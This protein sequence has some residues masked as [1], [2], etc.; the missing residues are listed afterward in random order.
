MVTV[1]REGG[2]RIVIYKDDHVP[3]H[4]HVIGDGEVIVNLSGADG[5]PEVRQHHG[6]T[7]ADIR[8]ALRIVTGRLVVL[9]AK[10]REIHGGLD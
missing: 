10:W 8:K 2:F 9:L 6:S 4:V 5:Q 3:A 1:H 7:T